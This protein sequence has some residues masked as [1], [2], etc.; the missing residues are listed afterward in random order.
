[1]S[2]N[3][4]Q[5]FGG[6]TGDPM[7]LSAAIG[8]GAV[9]IFFG[10]Y[11]RFRRHK[12]MLKVV[13][14]MLF[15][16]VFS[17]TTAMDFEKGKMY[18]FHKDGFDFF[19]GSYL[20][21]KE[22]KNRWPSYLWYGY[23]VKEYMLGEKAGMLREEHKAFFESKTIQN[24]PHASIEKLENMLRER[25]HFGKKCERNEKKNRKM[26]LDIQ[27]PINYSPNH[28]VITSLRVVSSGLLTGLGVSIASKITGRKANFLKHMTNGLFAGVLALG[29]RVMVD[30]IEKNSPKY[31]SRSLF[32][33]GTAALGACY[34]FSPELFPYALTHAQVSLF[35]K[36]VNFLYSEDCQYYDDL[37]SEHEKRADSYKK[38]CLEIGCQL[39]DISNKIDA[40][41]P[42][43][44]RKLY[45]SDQK[46][47]QYADVIIKTYD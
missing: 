6:E 13:M 30:K 27:K 3:T 29:R 2:R 45:Q 8:F 21:E 1:M 5:C 33:G 43:F 17:T 37:V 9:M 41:K 22:E 42:G 44:K 38:I 18:R 40:L 34:K 47:S 32:I 11:W 36:A 23:K 35:E 4:V 25:W 28:R 31:A 39:V 19:R 12:I 10:A 24:T 26:I 15:L 16:F 46:E 14:P 7:T 20:L